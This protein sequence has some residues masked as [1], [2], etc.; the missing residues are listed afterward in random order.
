MQRAATTGNTPPRPPVAKSAPTRPTALPVPEKKEVISAPPE[1]KSD[2]ADTLAQLDGFETVPGW[3]AA[4]KKTV[5]PAG[6]GRSAWLWAGVKDSVRNYRRNGRQLAAWWERWRKTA[7]CQVLLA[8]VAIYGLLAIM[9]APSDVAVER[10]RIAEEVTFLQGF[11]KSYTAAGGV[12]LA[13]RPHGGSELYPRGVVLKGDALAAFMRASAGAVFTVHVTAT[14]S[15]PLGG[16]YGFPPIYAGGEYFHLERKFNFSLYRCSYL[17][18][19]DSETAGVILLA[20]VE[21][22]Q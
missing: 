15:N 18:R 10:S 3:P 16:F 21:R 11:L 7:S 2:L 22:T 20:R 8:F 14:E 6:L 17:I 5:R 13:E 9:R 1:S 12:V 4:L 19:K